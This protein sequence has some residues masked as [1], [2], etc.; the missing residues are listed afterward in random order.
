MRSTA[1]GVTDS[2][3]GSVPGDESPVAT[4]EAVE[5]IANGASPNGELGVWLQKLERLELA[6]SKGDEE[7][8]ARQAAARRARWVSE[9]ERA[10]HAAVE[11]I[12]REAGERRA[13]WRDE[14][15]RL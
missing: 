10:E 14:D 6:E 11:R 8:R 7:R 12:T 4:P 1:T 5:S 15:E 9:Y 13:R 2:S 3:Q